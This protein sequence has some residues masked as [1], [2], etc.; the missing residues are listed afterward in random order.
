[1]DTGSLVG[2]GHASY[3]S[4]P[5]ADSVTTV[6]DMSLDQDV[7]SLQPIRTCMIIIYPKGIIVNSKVCG[8]IIHNLI[9]IN[10][11][12]IFKFFTVY[13]VTHSCRFRPVS[14]E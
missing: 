2:S 9:R 6:S 4:C 12:G 8:H 5:L 14:S 3:D 10:C 13:K 11:K 1:M 7:D